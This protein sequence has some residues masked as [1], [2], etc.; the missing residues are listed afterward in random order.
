MH[1]FSELILHSSTFILSILKEIEDRTMQDLYNSPETIHIKKLQMINLQKTF[2][3]IGVFSYYESLLQERLNSKNGFA[4]VKKILKNNN[5]FQ[6]LEEFNELQCIVNV[7]KHGKGSSYNELLQKQKRK[8]NINIKHRNLNYFNEGNVNEICSII[9]VD[10]KFITKSVRLI[11][12]IAI[13][14]QKYN[15]EVII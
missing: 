2:F 3:F 11:N 12:A 5:E 4:E 14:I 15:P 1:N 7:L 9:E 13:A 8:I 6:L 10:D